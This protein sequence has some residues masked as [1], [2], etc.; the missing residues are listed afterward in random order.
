M[1]KKIKELTPEEFEEYFLYTP[2][3]DE[4]RDKYIELLES[5]SPASLYE[6]ALFIIDIFDR[7]V[8]VKEEEQ[9]E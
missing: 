8:D 4:L 5:D 7:E 9:C 3:N 6:L 2:L 1:I